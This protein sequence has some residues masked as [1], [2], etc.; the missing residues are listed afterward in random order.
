MTS[1]T[2]SP[3]SIISITIHHEATTFPC[4]DR[5]SQYFILAHKNKGEQR[6][7]GGL[8][9]LKPHA[10]RESILISSM[11]IGVFDLPYQPFTHGGATD[12]C[13]PVVGR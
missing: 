10:E 6:E 9:R 3:E 11:P 5:S 12:K 1:G 4:V 13:E 8:L 7:L 2:D